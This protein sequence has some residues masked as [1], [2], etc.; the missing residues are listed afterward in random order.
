M[1]VLNTKG[2][3]LSLETRVSCIVV[4]VFRFLKVESDVR[5]LREALGF[6]LQLDGC[7][8]EVMVAVNVGTWKRPCACFVDVGLEALGCQDDV[9][10][11]VN[12]PIRGMPGGYPRQL[13]GVESVGKGESVTLCEL[14]DS[15]SSVVCLSNAKSS[16]FSC[17]GLVCVRAYLN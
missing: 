17:P 16:H 3:I 10:L 8:H 5:A 11:V 14:L 7:K 4:G 6:Q 13:V 15:L 1:C 9:Y 12:L 2:L